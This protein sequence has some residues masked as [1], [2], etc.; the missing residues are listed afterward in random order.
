MYLI[1]NSIDFSYAID[2]ITSAT[3]PN[4]IQQG[5]ILESDKF[6]TTFIAPAILK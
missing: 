4:I 1:K 3:D 2:K 6:N 5:S